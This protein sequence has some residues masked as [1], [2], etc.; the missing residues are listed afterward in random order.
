[1]QQYD[2]SIGYQKKFF[3]S[4]YLLGPFSG[5]GP[6]PFGNGVDLLW[7]CRIFDVLCKFCCTRTLAS[8]S[9]F[10]ASLFAADSIS[11]LRP[12][13]ARTGDATV[14]TSLKILAVSPIAFLPIASVV[15]TDPASIERPSLNSCE[16]NDDAWSPIAETKYPV[17]CLDE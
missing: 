17:V 13:A 16:A 11:C 10:S 1:M 8:L 6:P 4:D 7:F 14:A 5:A 15:A 12:I 3:Q 2:Y 9:A